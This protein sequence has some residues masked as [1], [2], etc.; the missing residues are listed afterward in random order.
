M[1]DLERLLEALNTSTG[2]MKKNVNTKPV[3]LN[4]MDFDDPRVARAYNGLMDEVIR[5]NNQYLMRTNEA[6]GL[7]AK[8][9]TIRSLL[10]EIESQAAP[11]KELARSREIFENSTTGLDEKGLRALTFANEIEQALAMAAETEGIDARNAD[12][13]KRLSDRAA[14]V[15]QSCKE[16][17]HE[18]EVQNEQHA[19]LLENIE[20]LSRSH[21][22]QVAEVLNIGQNVQIACRTFDTIRSDMYRQNAQ[23]TLHDKLTVFAMDHTI[24]GWRLYNNIVE[25]ETLVPSQVNN[26]EGCKF[27]LWANNEA[28]EWLMKLPCFQRAY[29]AHL[30]F[31]AHA[32]ESFNAKAAYDT[33]AA[34][35]AFEAALVSLN[36][37]TQALDELHEVLRQHGTNKETDFANWV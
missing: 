27:G 36:E 11:L 34:I 21:D 24:L 1:D 17:Y 14:Q 30:D 4:E 25:F 16:L 18:I 13:L 28:P 26:P 22:N 20:V 19:P 5:R 15:S 37:M 2:E 7:L 9:Y 12:I 32:V 3:R 35:Q 29:Q 10:E 8:G 23:P 33:A 31:H 6:I